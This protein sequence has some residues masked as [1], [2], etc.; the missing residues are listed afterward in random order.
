MSVF[1]TIAAILVGYVLFASAS[2]ML[3]GP[4]MAQQGPMIV[5]LALIA[6]AV[7]GLVVGFVAAMIAGSKRLL[8]GYIVAG[9]VCLATLANLVMQLG[10]EPVWYKVATLFV[11]APLIVLVCRR[12]PSV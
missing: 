5:V 12:Q 4:V 8:A 10:A 1:R 7:I 11:T 3:V 2:M 9:L 6:L